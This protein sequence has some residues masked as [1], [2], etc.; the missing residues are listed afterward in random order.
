MTEPKTMHVWMID[1]RS[2][3]DRRAH[4]APVVD[5][6]DEEREAIRA[7]SAAAPACGA[8]LLVAG[9][10]RR[11]AATILERHPQ[12]EPQ[13]ASQS[14][15]TLKGTRWANY[16]DL[17]EVETSAER[18]DANDYYGPLSGKIDPAYIAELSGHWDYLVAQGA[19]EN[20]LGFKGPVTR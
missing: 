1:G 16:F 11:E 5:Q 19:D 14:W 4:P 15:L 13:R 9:R 20:D 3:C 7:E 6:T 10:I 2:L 8:C 17:S 12:V 18:M